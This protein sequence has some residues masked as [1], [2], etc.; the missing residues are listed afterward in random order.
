MENFR[1]IIK[2]K[3]KELGLSQSQLAEKVGIIQVTLSN[4]ET[5]KSELGADKLEKIFEILNIKVD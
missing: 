5:G 3:R 2:K 4:Y 1:E